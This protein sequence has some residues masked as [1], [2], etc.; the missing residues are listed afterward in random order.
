VVSPGSFMFS[1]ILQTAHSR[2]P[3]LGRSAIW[4]A[5]L[6]A[7]SGLG[8]RACGQ[9]A[10]SG[11]LSKVSLSRQSED[12]RVIVVALLGGFVPRSESHHPEVQLIRQLQQEYPVGAYFRVFENHRIDDAYKAILEQLDLDQT[13]TATEQNKHHIRVVLLGHSW[14]ASAVVRLARKLEHKGVPIALTVQVDSVAKPF[15]DDRL[16]PA[17]VAEAANF[18]Q[19][20]G[21]IHGRSEIRAADPKRTTIIGNFRREYKTEPS[22]CRQFPWYSRLFTKGHI[23]IECDPDLW[24]EVKTLLNPYLP[25]EAS[26]Q[27]QSSLIQDPPITSAGE[28]ARPEQTEGFE[29]H[30]N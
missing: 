7:T 6:A 10:D 29:F 15:S 4:V 12:N 11:V 26:T 2:L 19:T 5:I 3:T 21:L 14:G 17:N 22:A 16:I 9:S 23:E 1:A 8:I 27:N 20:R 24:S 28:V 18:Y 30:N 13:Q 25:H